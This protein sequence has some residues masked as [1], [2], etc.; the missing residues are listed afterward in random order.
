MQQWKHEWFKFF[1]DDICEN[2]IKIPEILIYYSN[3]NN[4]YKFIKKIKCD[5]GI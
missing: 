4:K 2:S 3:N 5:C 1:N